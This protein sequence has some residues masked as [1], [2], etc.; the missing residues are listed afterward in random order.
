MSRRAIAA[1]LARADLS[2]G[3]RLVAFSLASFADR[4]NR[5]RPGTPAAAGRAGLK[6]SW[7]LEAREMLERRGL[8][9]VERA[10]TGRGRASSLW[11][12]FAE[13][14]PWWEG[15]I[16]AELFESV[17][18][19]SR[20]RGSAR[21]LL[22]AAAALADQERTV[23]GF[24]T[25]QLCAAANLTDTTYRRARV[26]LLASGELVLRRGTGGRG[27]TNCWE[28]ADP[29]SHAS[30][31]EAV[32]RRRVAP[33]AGQRPL[34]PTVSSNPAP[35]AQTRPASPADNADSPG[36]Y[37]VAHPL[38]G[39]Q[40][41]TLYSLN[42]PLSAGVSSG[43][44]A[45][46]RTLSPGNRPAGAGVPT[47]KGAADRTLF[48]ETPATTPPETPPPNARAGREPQNPRT[49][50]PPRP[51][52]GGSAG[53]QVL[54]EETYVSA[55]GRRRRRPVAV[56]LG[57]MRARFRAAG[58]A[59]H[60]AWKQIRAVLLDVVGE[61][62]FEIWLAP[63]ELVAVDLQGTLV[64][65]APRET[66]GWVAGRFGR[67]LDS[68]AERAGLRLRVAD[69]VERQAA[70]ALNS[71]AAAAP[72]GLSPRKSGQRSSG[73]RA[74][75]SSGRSGDTPADGSAYPPSYT[76]VYNQFKGVS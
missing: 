58:G 47:G 49:T 34:I 25:R 56:D 40:D 29:R 35:A 7:F 23:E 38:N 33:P 6:R 26:A 20:A 50:D 17:L 67:I 53:D 24:T 75:A 46:D 5:A 73:F 52:E 59:D 54:V 12:P 14:G 1:V 10:A 18:T 51:P 69:E 60:A 28:I 36:E 30:P 39:A 27:N 45:A 2:C 76:D 44:G 61:S 16:N 15:E 32:G 19:Y 68:A 3:E 4:E 63:L 11:L 43:N 62:A 64:V 37:P 70:A 72:P 13:T 9:V 65:S 42:C 22:A 74:D 55:R 71:P 57:A 48:A 41:R 8:V 66:A 21:L 31:L